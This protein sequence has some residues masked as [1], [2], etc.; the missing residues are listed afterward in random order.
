MMSGIKVD[1]IIF[2]I[3]TFVVNIDL[4]WYRVQRDPGTVVKFSRKEKIIV[5]RYTARGTFKKS[6]KHL[7]L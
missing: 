3:G 5:L 4:F 1:L 6:D 2:I 7:Q